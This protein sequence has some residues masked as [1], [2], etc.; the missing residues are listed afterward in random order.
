MTDPVSGSLDQTHRRLP[1]WE[2]WPGRLEAEIGRFAAHDL[3]VTLLEDPREGADRLVIQTSMDLPGHGP[4]RLVVVYPAGFPHRRFAIYAPDLRLSR[5]Q[6]PGGNLCVLARGADNWHPGYMGADIAYHRVPE[7]VAV[8]EEGGERLRASEDPQGEPVTAYFNSQQQGGIIIDQRGV[9]VDAAAAA[10]G[11]MTLGFAREDMTWLNPP[12]STGEWL[13]PVGQ[14]LLLALQDRNRAQLLAEPE[15]TLAGRYPVR[16]EGRWVYFADPPYAETAQQLWD[17]VMAADDELS[18]WAATHTG[19]ALIGVCMPEEIEQGVYELGWVF[20]ARHAWKQPPPGIKPK[21]RRGRNAPMPQHGIRVQTEPVIVRALRWTARDL[22]IR[23]PELA[24]MRTAAVSVVGLGSLGAPF[25]QEMA[26]AR[27]GSL[28]LAD[29]DHIEPGTSVRHPLGLQFAGFHKVLALAQW[30]HAHNPEVEVSVTDLQVGAIALNHG[31]PS[32]DEKISAILA[33]ADLLVSAT[34]EH[35]VNRQLD[36][37]AI[38]EG[39]ARLY[40]W[41]QSGY[42]GVV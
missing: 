10:S 19:Y 16:C 14:G 9:G 22:S 6:A 24:P 23:I 21:A 1:W 7:L 4:T 26:K 2:R 11:R 29:F 17:A 13:P 40:L 12:P 38:A 41:S 33:G 31:G 15:Q 34:A 37:E 42:G 36:Q 25:V 3:D 5:H 20:L 27:I 35:D 18:R 28:H 8:V 39:V 30:I 32:E